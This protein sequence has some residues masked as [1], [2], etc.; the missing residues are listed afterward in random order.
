LKEKAVIDGP[1]ILLQDILEPL[2]VGGLG[3]LKMGRLG[4]PGS[5]RMVTRD[6]VLVK[7]AK[8]LKHAPPSILGAG[9][10]VVAS[11]REIPGA[12]LLK[13]AHQAIEAQVAG[14]TPSAK[15][16]IQDP[17]VPSALQVPD[18]P[19]VL[20]PESSHTGIWRGRV[21]LRIVARQKVPDDG[22]QEV[23]SSTLSF[24]AKRPIRRGESIGSENAALEMQ[25]V[26]YQQGD[27]FGDTGSSYGLTA[28]RPIAAGS[29]LTGDML[30]LPFVIKRGDLLK[31]Q[32]RSGRVR[33]E[34]MA[35]A[36]RD[37]RKGESIPVEVTDTHKKMNATVVGPGMVEAVKP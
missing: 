27:G 1:V 10:L 33:V 32:V 37:G 26:T 5:S 7:M 30:E 25:D 9:C 6:Q 14:L 2:P 3:Q 36:L 15:V 31:L 23:G 12:D 28:R 18:R 19:V 11:H 34:A 22:L 13:F 24:V 4:R 17:P 35:S 16:V 21:I 20:A 29:V 8:Y